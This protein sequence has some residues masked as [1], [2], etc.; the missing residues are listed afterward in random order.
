MFKKLIELGGVFKGS[1][2]VLGAVTLAYTAIELYA[3]QYKELASLLL[4][5]VGLT[6]LPIGIVDAATNKK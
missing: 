2:R 3:P 1:K 6:L 4:Q 5:T